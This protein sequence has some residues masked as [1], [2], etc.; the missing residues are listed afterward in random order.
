LP[1]ALI[2]SANDCKNNCK[3]VLVGKFT[4]GDSS[5]ISIISSYI[6]NSQFS[7]SVEVNFGKEPIGMFSLQIGLNPIIAAKYFSGVDTSSVLNVNVNPALFA[8]TDSADT[9]V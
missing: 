5:A 7:F 3:D 1:Q 4:S 6:P 2:S 8:R 9:L